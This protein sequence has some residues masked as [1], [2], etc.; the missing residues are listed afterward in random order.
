ME[1]IL[2]KNKI[3]SNYF[4]LFLLAMTGALAGFL[5][6][7]LGSGGGIIL[8]FAMTWLCPKTETKERF[9][10]AV[11]A[12]LPLSAFSTFIYLKNGIFSLYDSLKFLIP[13]AVGGVF[14]SYI[15][16]KISPEFLKLIFSALMVFA[17]LRIITH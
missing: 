15:M 3:T 11:T 5:N 9:A 17:G 6:G 14:G 8:I 10:T 4:R 12:I 1:N 13:G 7:F 16:G 2:Q